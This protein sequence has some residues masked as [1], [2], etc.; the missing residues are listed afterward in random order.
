[1][2]LYPNLPQDVQ[3]EIIGSALIGATLQSCLNWAQGGFKQS[4]ETMVEHL[5]F[6]WRG[7][8]DWLTRLQAEQAKTA[9]APIQAKPAAAG[10]KAA[11]K[12]QSK[13]PGKAAK[14]T[15]ATKANKA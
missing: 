1:E 5:L 7:L 14:T 9:V 4:I 3:L 2:I 11:R 15:T 6:I 10:K 12:T 8:D 13:A